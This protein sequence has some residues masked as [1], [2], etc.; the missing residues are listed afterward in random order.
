MMQQIV[1]GLIFLSGEEGLELE[2]LAQIVELSSDECLSLL[3]ELESKHQND[4]SSLMLVQYAKRYKFVT[5]PYLKDYALK[6]LHVNKVKQLSQSALETLA[7]IAYK[8]PVTRLEIED[9]RGVS[10]EMMLRKLMAL[11]L[12]A[13]AGRLDTVGRPVLYQ[14]TQAFLDGFKMTSLD[15]L[16]DLDVIEDNENE[17]LFQ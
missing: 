2:Q 7:I 1:E 12:V 4:A 15:E 9:I 3:D 17:E 13:E 6:F 5:K 8:Q 10:S 14:V 11:D 16:P